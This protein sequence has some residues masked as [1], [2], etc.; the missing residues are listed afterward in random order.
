MSKESIKVGN[1]KL[2]FH[3]LHEKKL[4]YQQKEGEPKYFVQVI[5]DKDEHKKEIEQIKLAIDQIVTEK[6]NGKL[7]FQTYVCLRDGDDENK[8]YLANKHILK[9]STKIEI[10]RL[11]E[12]Q[13]YLGVDADRP[14]LLVRPHEILA[15]FYEG[16]F[17]NI[18]FDVY[19]FSSKKHGSRMILSEL[20]GVQF[21]AEGEA[22]RSR[23]IGA[24]EFS[25]FEQT[26][27]D[28]IPF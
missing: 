23:P 19:Y 22:F 21:K 6:F 9:A 25:F 12:K 4:G 8:P 1:V 20:K 17:V 26:Y 15:K 2:A 11:D 16:C 24:S 18:I 14:D 28:D 3:A 7:P 13:N 5:L 27:N 10:P